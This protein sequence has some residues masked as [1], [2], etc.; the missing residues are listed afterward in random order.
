MGKKRRPKKLALPRSPFLTKAKKPGFTH[1]SRI[2]TA[3]WSYRVVRYGFLL[4]VVVLLYMIMNNILYPGD[5]SL[6]KAKHFLL[7]HPTNPNSHLLLGK[8]LLEKRDREHAQKEIALAREQLGTSDSSGAVLGESTALFERLGDWEDTPKKIEFEL[9]FWKGVIERFTDYRDA[10][11]ELAL[12]SLELHRLD[13]A[14]S[15]AQ[16]ALE[17]DPD[18]PL[19]QKIMDLVT[20]NRR[21]EKEKD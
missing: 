8:V 21:Y 10:Y 7:S 14:K 18:H 11:Q 4:I 15:Y 17:L 16:K 3:A 19:S 5:T 1:N 2:F 12:L 20:I 6:V 9:A 13:D